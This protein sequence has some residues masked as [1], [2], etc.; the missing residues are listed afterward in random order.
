MSGIFIPTL[1]AMS[2]VCIF[3][4]LHHGFAVMRRRVNRIHLLFA[5][6]CLLLTAIILTK[7][8]AYQA[9]T[10]LALVGIR[11]WEV[12]F[13]CLFFSL[14]PWFIAEYTDIRPRK[15]L[16][17][18]SVFWALLFAVNLILP[19]G[20]QFIELPRLSYF[21]LPWGDRVVDLRV[22]QH[23]VWQHI[24]WMG[25]F[26]LMAYS[27]YACFSQYRQG[28]Q[29]KARVLAWAL[30]LF[31]GI[32][33]V[34]VAVHWGLIEFV[35]TSEFGFVSLLVLMDF[36]MMLEPR[37][38]KQRMRTVL[39]H[40]PAAICLKDLNGRYQLINRKF[41]T[42][43]HV[44]SAEIIGKTDLYLFSLEKAKA[45]RTNELLA[46][47]KREEVKSEEEL[48]WNGKPHIYESH[49]FPLLRPDGLPYAVVGMYLDIT[50]SRQKDEAL[51]KF[52]QQ[53][54]R[55]SRMSS[56]E[57][58][59]GSLAHELCQPLSAILNNAQAGLRFLAKD[60]VELAEIRDILQDIVRD[61]KRAGAVI[62]GLR[63]MLQQ[64]ETPFAKIDLAPCMEEVIELLHSEFIRLGVDVEY[65]QET[66]LTVWANKTQIQ[67]VGL[68]LMMNAMEAMVEQPAGERI[69]LVMTKRTDDKVQVSIRDNGIGIPEDKMSRIFE[70]FYTTKP[71]GLGVGLEVC[72]SI[73]ESHHGAFWV[74]ANQDRGV[75][76]HFTLPIYH[77]DR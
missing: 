18:L 24:M 54:W 19:Y 29:R 59:A 21:E 76:F 7:A 44:A 17:G 70:S 55:N 50:E 31:L 45:F 37:N 53:V 36:E 62:N 33:L 66:N 9:E 57:A 14:F 11:R 34:N 1:Y 16:A 52:R 75:T 73:I 40:L 27:L 6:L 51:H 28:E 15:L 61:D 68:N 32:I 63:A 71:Q 60:E 39:D 26:A 5:L 49:Q 22:H 2:G 77:G 43:F 65:M 13:I 64:Q 23:N 74:E 56:T 12:S 10:S 58:I 41:E 48:E 46:I 42:L 30:I 69:L 38:Q 20:V 35:H 47:E 72:R 4:A 8:G 67:Q 25:V 3:A